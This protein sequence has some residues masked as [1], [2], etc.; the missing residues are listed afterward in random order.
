M[1]KKSALVATTATTMTT[2][3]NKK[4][5]ISFETQVETDTYRIR[6][7]R[8]ISFGNVVDGRTSKKTAATIVLGTMICVMATHLASVAYLTSSLT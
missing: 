7:R 5:K 2:T 8:R 6:K 3:G 1:S 4:R